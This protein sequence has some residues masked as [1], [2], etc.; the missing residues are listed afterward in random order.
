MPVIATESVEAISLTI[1]RRP[2]AGA[3]LRA[4]ENNC[5]LSSGTPSQL[6]LD[7]GSYTSGAALMSS[8]IGGSR[9]HEQGWSWYSGRR[10]FSHSIPPMCLLHETWI[11][12][13]LPNYEHIPSTAFFPAGSSMMVGPCNSSTGDQLHIIIEMVIASHRTDIFRKRSTRPAR[14]S[15]IIDV[16]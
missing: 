7:I 11:G 9:E 10:S 3:L 14:S 16:L 15:L 13:H 8:D 5:N 6:E 4:G 1:K 12:Q 2:L